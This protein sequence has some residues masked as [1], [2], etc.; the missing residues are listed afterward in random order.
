[1]FAVVQGDLGD[2]GALGFRQCSHEYGVG[3]ADLS[4]GAT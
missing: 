1:V 2:R 3:L 4:S